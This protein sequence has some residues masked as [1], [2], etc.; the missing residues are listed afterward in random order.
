[1]NKLNAE[2]YCQAFQAIFTQ[3]KA[4]KP[5]FEVGKSLKGNIA[6]WSDTQYKGL[7][8]AVVAGLAGDI[9]KGCQVNN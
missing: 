1:M 2:A 7:E 9:V 4:V 6:D 3:V 5:D 8:M